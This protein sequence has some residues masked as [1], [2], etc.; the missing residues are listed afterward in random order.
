M[1]FPKDNYKIFTDTI[2]PDKAPA[3]S[4]SHCLHPLHCPILSCPQPLTLTTR[5]MMKVR[6]NSCWL[7][8][9]P[10]E[11]IH[12]NMGTGECQSLCFSGHTMILLQTLPLR[13]TYQTLG[14]VVIR[15]WSHWSRRWWPDSACSCL[16]SSV[17]C[18]M[19]I[20]WQVF[21]LLVFFIDSFVACS[22][23][24]SFL[25]VEKLKAWNMVYGLF[26]NFCSVTAIK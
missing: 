8:S 26:P 13:Q 1:K 21:M 6:N 2:V 20:F 11:T 23:S 3:G 16:F 19:N 25:D 7:S 10:V 5:T 14:P 15:M 4:S 24:W 18:L 12:D 17:L 22:S 9:S